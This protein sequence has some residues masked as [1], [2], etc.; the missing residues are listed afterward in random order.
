MGNQMTSSRPAVAMAWPKVKPSSGKA[1]GISHHSSR[2][3][4]PKATPTPRRIRTA[5]RRTFKGILFVGQLR[6]VQPQPAVQAVGDGG[7][8]AGLGNLL[9]VRQQRL[10]QDVA[11]VDGGPLGLG[12]VL[13]G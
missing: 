11:L 12:Q 10:T 6:G 4:S 5:A 13:V 9:G 3:S 1:I 7:D 2:D 8:G